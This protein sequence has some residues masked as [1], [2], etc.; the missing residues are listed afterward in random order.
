MVVTSLCKVVISRHKFS[1]LE[2][3]KVSKLRLGCIMKLNG[4]LTDSSRFIYFM[5]MN[6][7]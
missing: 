4:R 2:W 1:W 7:L 5:Y 3:E 6:T